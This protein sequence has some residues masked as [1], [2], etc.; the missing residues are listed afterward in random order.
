MRIRTC[1]YNN[2]Y[3]YYTSSYCYSPHNTANYDAEM[4]HDEAYVDP[5]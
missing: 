4:N 5:V 2:L 1:D 3:T